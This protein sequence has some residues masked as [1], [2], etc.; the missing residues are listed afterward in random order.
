MKIPYW[1]LLVLPFLSLGIGYA[2]NAIVMAA[3]HG[4]M[5]VQDWVHCWNY[6]ADGDF[7]HS[8]MT[9][10]THLKF[11]ADWFRI[12]GTGWYSM[13]DLFIML[14]D[15]ILDPCLVIWAVLMIKKQ[16]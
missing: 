3:N 15:K 11:L 9:P 10:D 6:P 5:P 1:K 2:L 7:L 16:D 14:S 12:P 8:C 4:Q 13:G